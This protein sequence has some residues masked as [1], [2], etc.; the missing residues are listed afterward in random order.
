MTKIVV[1]G[2]VSY[3]TILHLSALPEP[4][5]QN[6]YAQRTLE[7]VGSTGSG[8]AVN[9]HQL[10]FEVVFHGLIGEDEYGE[11]VERYFAQKGLPFIYDVDP[12]GT[13]RH[14][15]LIDPHG[16]RISIYAQSASF[17]PHIQWSHIEPHIADCDLVALNIINYCREAIPLIKQSGKPIWCDIHDYDGRN[18]YHQEFIDAADVIQMSSDAL[19][20]YRP[21]MEKF[22]AQGKQLVICTHGKDG[23][24]ALTAAGKWH[25]QP[26][27]TAFDPIDTNGAG[28]SFFS[29]VLFGQLHG[30]TLADSLKL[31]AL[32]SALCVASAE[33]AHPEL[34]ADGLI[35]QLQ[36]MAQ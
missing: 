28:D 23:A 26:I 14:I 19:P 2:G 16:G 33:I 18:P 3:D 29:G 6:V 5:P 10:G 15:N 35:G 34:T 9:L 36:R 17:E 1:L 25:T 27:I 7:M 11:R 30:H 22:I 32:T 21:L 8:K 12:Q 31:G 24:E 20:E 4:R 13:E